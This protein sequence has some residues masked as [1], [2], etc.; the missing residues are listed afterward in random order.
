MRF[1][2]LL[3]L[4]ILLFLTITVQAGQLRGL[5][6]VRH[7]I[8]SPTEW[9]SI[10]DMAEELQIT[11]LYVQVRALGQRYGLN[12]TSDQH[13]PLRN[14]IF[15]A[16][17]KGIRIHAWL[18]ALYIWSGENAPK[19]SNHLFHRA[20][21]SILRSMQDIAIPGYNQYRAQ[22]I[23]GFYIDPS[24][25][26]NLLDLKILI[27]E[28]IHDYEVD[29]IHLDYIRYPG[30][31]YSFSPSVRTHFMV[32]N[33]FD[34]VE[35]YNNLSGNGRAN[36]AESFL[37][38]DKLYRTVL[39]EKLNKLVTTLFDYSNQFEKKIQFSLAVK[40][41]RR[42]AR[43]KYFQDW[44][45]WLEDNFCDQLLLMNYQTDFEEFKHNIREAK[46]TNHESKIVIGISTY[47][48]DYKAVLERIQYINSTPLAGFALFSYNHLREYKDYYL[49]LSNA[50]K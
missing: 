31:E 39:R 10:L 22:G 4:I 41:N 5:W 46:K 29:G 49:K 6:V 45:K 27:A 44:G 35:I 38:A 14:L 33:W 24:D 13:V 21:T 7:A 36:S 15:Q 18:N 11:D 32:A 17:L 47:N 37:F 23:E 2:I 34:P 3:Y 20:Q 43:D 25:A 8:T 26:Q 28:L 30:F 16:K 48:Q 9:Q 40:P 19:E 12:P 42:T 50:I 1:R